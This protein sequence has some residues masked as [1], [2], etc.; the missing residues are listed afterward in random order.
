MDA[1]TKSMHEESKSVEAEIKS[2][3]NA[4]QDKMD[5]SI[6]NRKDDRQETTFCQETTEARL[7]CE[8]PTSRDTK[9]FHEVTERDT[10]N[11]ELDP[12]TMQF[13][14]EH[15][16]IPKEAVT[17]MVVGGLRKW[18]RYQNLAA[19]RRQK[20]KGK[21]QAS[22]D[23]RRRLTV[24]GRKMTCRATV[25]WRKKNAVRK[26]G[27]RENCGLCKELAATGIG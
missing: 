19:G 20:R 16:E 26:I 11:T 1:N 6:A 21:I 2:T 27:T 22:C 25:A 24:A 7:A 10:E 17:V 8:E 13:M 23:S 4:F 12:G 9:A 3:V 15:Q 14:E 5:A 18:R